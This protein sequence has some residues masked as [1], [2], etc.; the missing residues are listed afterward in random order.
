M[1]VK[2]NVCFFL[3]FI[4]PPIG[5]IYILMNR[6][7][8]QKRDFILY[9]LF[10]AINISLWLSLMIFDRTM[11]MVAGHYV[12]GAIVIVFSKMNKG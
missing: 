11:W 12:L 10:A 4:L 9:V 1:V 3:C 2:K 8:L 6:E 5:A 7:S